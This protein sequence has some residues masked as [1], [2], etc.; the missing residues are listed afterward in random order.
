MKKGA[1]I[2]N[3]LTA[4]LPRKLKKAL[5]KQVLVNR[6]PKRQVPTKAIRILK[7]FNNWWQSRRFW[8]DAG[9]HRTWKINYVL[10]YGA[11][12]VYDYE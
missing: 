6:G 3:T 9:K 5:K 1:S 2:T 7:A 10:R 12:T 8:R 4:K 11:E